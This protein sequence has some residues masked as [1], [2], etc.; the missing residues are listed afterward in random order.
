MKRVNFSGHL[1]DYGE[2]P[3]KMVAGFVCAMSEQMEISRWYRWR[4]YWI[5]TTIWCY[6]CWIWNTIHEESDYVKRIL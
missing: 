4:I 5:N 3:T 2:I 6:F 1:S